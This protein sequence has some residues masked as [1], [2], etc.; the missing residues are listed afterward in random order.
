MCIF[1][2]KGKF[3][4]S[5]GQFVPWW[6][7]VKLQDHVEFICRIL[8]QNL[9]PCFLLFYFNCSLAFNSLLQN[10]EHTSSCHFFQILTCWFFSHSSTSSSVLPSSFCVYLCVQNTVVKEVQYLFL[11]SSAC[12]W[13]KKQSLHQRPFAHW[14]WKNG[15]GGKFWLPTQYPALPLC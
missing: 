8:C 14:E 7:P 10:M 2:L 6:W 11:L 13:W 5:I 15:A 3:C 9:I 12:V 1:I 4:V